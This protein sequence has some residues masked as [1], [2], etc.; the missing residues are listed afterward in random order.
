MHWRTP[1]PIVWGLV[2]LLSAFAL[3]VVWAFVVFLQGLFKS[4][5]KLSYLQ[6]EEGRGIDERLRKIRKISFW[7]WLAMVV[8]MI[9]LTIVALIAEEMKR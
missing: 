8:G 2:A 4:G 3:S 5:R 7:L 9:L 6:S 1:E